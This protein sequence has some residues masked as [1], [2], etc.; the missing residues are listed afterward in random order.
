[1]CREIDYACVA[2]A[3]NELSRA[4]IE[5]DQSPARVHEDAPLPAIGPRRDAAVHEARAVGWLAVVVGARVIDPEWPARVRIHR[6]DSIIRGAEEERIA[7]HERR[8][9]KVPRPRRLGAVGRRNRLLAGTP[10]PRHGHPPNVRA[11]DVG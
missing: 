10:A 11:I 9:L 2:K 6:H 5:G 3:A 8:R 4:A 7:D 1:M